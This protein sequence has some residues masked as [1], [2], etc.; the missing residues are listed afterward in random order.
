MSIEEFDN[1]FGKG[2]PVYF[3]NSFDEIVFYSLGNGEFKG[4][5]KGGKEFSV[6]IPNTKLTEALLEHN[7]ISKEEYE[8]Y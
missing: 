7:A 3:I 6:E 8:K 4:K 2:Q 1:L 5:N